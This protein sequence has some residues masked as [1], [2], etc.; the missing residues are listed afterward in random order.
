V[1]ELAAPV[2]GRPLVPTA[3]QIEVGDLPAPVVV[4]VPVDQG[5]PLTRGGWRR[6]VSDLDPRH[7]EG[8]KKVLLI[9]CLSSLFLRI[10]DAAL[11]VLLPS[12]RAEFGVSLTFFTAV[13]SLVGVVAIGLQLP[14]GYL[15][16]RV[17]R[18]RL[19]RLG[20]LLTAGSVAAQGAV[21]S[22]TTLVGARVV[23]GVGQG[24]TTPASFPLMTDWFRPTS[25]TRVFGIYLAAAQLGLVVG[26]ITAGLLGDAFGWRAALLFLGGLATLVA[27]LTFLLREPARGAFERPDAVER[28]DP[29]A[30]GFAESYRAAAS[31]ATLRRLWYATPLLSARGIFSLLVLPVF[32]FDIYGLSI[33]QLGIVQ[34]I[35]GVLGL[36]ALL[37]AGVIGDR[38]LTSRPGRYM[39]FMGLIAAMQAG[40]IAFISFR[41]PVLLAIAAVQVVVVLEAALTPAFYALIATVVPSRIRG[42]G[43]ATQTPWQLI[44]VIG[45]PFLIVLVE[46]IGLQRGILLFVPLLLLAGLILGTGASGVERDIRAARAA[47]AAE[48]ALRQARERGTTPLL[49]CR[50][51]QVAYGGVQ[52][53]F[54]VDL[55]VQEGEVVALVGTNG[56]GK[57][58]LLRALAGTSEPSG[59]AVFFDDRDT[60]H[61]PPHSIAALGIVSMPGGAA[62]FPALSVAENL[63]AAAWT[64]RDDPQTVEQRTQEVLELFPVLRQR[65]DSPAGELSGGEQQMVGLSQALLMA[66]RLLLVDELSLGLAP[67]IVEQL[68]GVLRELN[69]RG[70]TIVMVEQS[71]NVALT[72]ADRAVFM[73]KGEIRFD[74][75]TEELLARPDLVRSVFMGGAAGGTRAVRRTPPAEQSVTTAL[76]VR[77]LAVS[78]G[79]VEALR[80]VDLTVSPGEVVG[81]IGPNGAG[82]TTLFDLV[83]G[84]TRPDRG[85][86]LLAGVDVTDA[87]PDARA[88]AG[89]GRSFQSARLFPALTVRE[90]IAVALERRAVR[91]PLLAAVWAP[92]VR[93]AERRIARRVDKLV[94][95]MGLEAY[96]DAT[97]AELSTGSRRAVDVA[98]ILALEP[99]L[100]LLDEPS[101]GL[102]QAETEA[103]GPLL[104]RIVRETGCGMLVIEH[105]LPLVTALSDRMVAME[106]GAVLVTGTPEQVRADPR[107]LASYLAASDDVVQRSG[108]L[109][110]LA[111]L[112]DESHPDERT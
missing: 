18:V 48:D 27:C 102:A 10:D 22:V 82:K 3:R 21:P 57:S 83:S 59:G 81:V 70:T 38:L 75:P 63:R 99:S 76:E 15:A 101:S 78:F 105:D 17:E 103:L 65:L 31:I 108:R 44:G 24:I 109:G 5:D 51:V 91:N 55:D 58:T 49:V 61:L 94:D 6:I 39:A 86:V 98:C 33:T 111:A 56:A 43:I 28:P 106:G 12:I 8:P 79:G 23:T 104:E 32:L 95:L 85:R 42:L 14:F 50:D 1:T 73:E 96:A 77:D 2:E 90:N 7:V 19:L 53:L 89:L 62:V 112:L 92:P 69:A 34:T 72:I 68:L 47:D 110:A 45:A 100:L 46:G 60:T 97:L 25:R 40:V 84:F 107:V 67:S 30:P 80:G 35:N 11:G 36:V 9:L 20:T 71:L 29:P 54:G 16:D 93:A 74:G 37:L 52:V 13:G 4:E 88:R 66:P 41:P 87:S 26:P 64:L